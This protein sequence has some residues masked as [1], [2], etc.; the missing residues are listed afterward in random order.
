MLGRSEISGHLVINWIKEYSF[1]TLIKKR[2]TKK[3]YVNFSGANSAVFAIF[4][5]SL[6][7]INSGRENG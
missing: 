4:D 3:K 6:V 2:K 5:Y 1:L 7:L